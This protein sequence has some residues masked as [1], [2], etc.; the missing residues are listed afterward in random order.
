MVRQM[1]LSSELQDEHVEFMRVDGPFVQEN[2]IF[3][4]VYF[5]KTVV[6]FFK[7]HGLGKF[8]EIKETIE[9]IGRR[10]F[11]EAGFRHVD[12]RFGFV[13][14]AGLT[15]WSGPDDC[16]FSRGVAQ[17]NR[18]HEWFLFVSSIPTPL[19]FVYLLNVAWYFRSLAEREIQAN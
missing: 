13:E 18:E 6:D 15:G 10:T 8:E 12:C 7:C 11:G 16:Y 5:H 1:P 19:H 2:G 9:S 3:C 4:R 17:E 14:E